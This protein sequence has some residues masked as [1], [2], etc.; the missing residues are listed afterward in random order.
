MTYGQ[1]HDRPSILALVHAKSIAPR[2]GTSSFEVNGKSGPE[3]GWSMAPYWTLVY[4]SAIVAGIC[5]FNS[6]RVPILEGEPT[7]STGR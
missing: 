6:A 4:K 5:V 7:N 2:F 3:F 1:E